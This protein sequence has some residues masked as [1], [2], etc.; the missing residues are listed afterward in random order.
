[1]PKT[2]VA[3]TEGLEAP[4]EV[5]VCRASNS[6][7]DRALFETSA[8]GNMRLTLRNFMARSVIKESEEVTR[9]ACGARN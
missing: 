3:R 5:Y 6:R 4:Y 1:M 8:R 7:T 2:K 9:K